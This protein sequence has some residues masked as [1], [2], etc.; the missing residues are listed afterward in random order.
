[1]Q[2]EIQEITQFY[3]PTTTRRECH[4]Q[5][6]LA[7]KYQTQ[8]LEIHQEFRQQG[9]LCWKDYAHQREI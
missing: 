4:R 3:H 7:T 9:I 1:M 5:L 2:Q 6:Q 8:L